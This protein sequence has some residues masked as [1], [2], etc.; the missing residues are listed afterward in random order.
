MSGV[1]LRNGIGFVVLATGGTEKRRLLE[2]T[3]AGRYWRVVHVW[4]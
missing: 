3:D 1:A 4:K 2:T